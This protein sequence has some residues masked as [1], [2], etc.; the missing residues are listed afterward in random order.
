MASLP[1]RPR[2]PGD[3]NHRL[4]AGSLFLSIGAFLAV[5]ILSIAAVLK[6]YVTPENSNLPVRTTAPSAAIQPKPSPL[7]PTIPASVK[8]SQG[9]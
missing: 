8:P 3:P 1:E 4:S 6:T 2:S 7:Q 9:Q 5:A